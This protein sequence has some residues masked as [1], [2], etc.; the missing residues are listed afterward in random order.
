MIH[1]I[2]NCQFRDFT[3]YAI[4]TQLYFKNILSDSSDNFHLI[5]LKKVGSEL[6]FDTGISKLNSLGKSNAGIL[7]YLLSADATKLTEK[8]RSNN[9]SPPNFVVVAYYIDEFDV[10]SNRQVW[11]NHFFVNTYFSTM[12]HGRNAAFI[13]RVGQYI[14]DSM[15]LFTSVTYSV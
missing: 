2:L 11:E 14:G 6:D 12:N 4:N 15:K 7:T 1:C 13:E 3:L 8:L 10:Y 5:E 9:L